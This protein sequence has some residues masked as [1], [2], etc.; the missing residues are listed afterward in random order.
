MQSRGLAMSYRDILVQAELI[1]IK[2][3]RSAGRIFGPSAAT[4]Q[5]CTGG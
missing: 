3:G 1:Q 4:L 2:I 5:P